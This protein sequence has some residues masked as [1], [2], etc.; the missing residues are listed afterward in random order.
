MSSPIRPVLILVRDGWG[1]AP[2][3]PGN[4]VSLAK[5]PRHDDLLKRFPVALVNASEHHVGLPVGQMGNSEVG[6]MSMG[7]GRVVHQ[8]F[9]R[10]EQDLEAHG[11]SETEAL[12]EAIDRAQERDRALHLIGLCSPGGVHSH[13]RHLRALLRLARERDVDEVYVHVITDG[14]DTSP[15]GGAD[16]VE[17]IVGWTQEF[18]AKIATVSGRYYAMDRDTRWDRIKQAYDAL[19][20]GRGV[21]I[22]DPVAYLRKCY[23]E[24][25]GDEFVLPAVVHEGGRRVASLQAGD[26][27][28]AFNF[29]ADRMRQMCQALMLHE[30]SDFDRGTSRVWELA[31]MTQYQDSLPFR[32]TAFPPQVIR[33][34]LCE[35]VSRTGRSQFKCAET[36]KYAHVTFFWNGGVE[37]PCPGEER[38]LIPS[39][40]VATYDL[41]PEMC[42]AAVADGV[43]GRLKS[44][45]DALLV[46]NL[47]NTDMVGHTGDIDATVVA[48][49]AVDAAVGQM[50]DAMLAKGG[51]V[52]ITADHGNCEQMLD[53]ETGAVHT[54]HTTN[55]VQLIACG[56]GLA[57]RTLRSGGGLSSVGPTALDLLGIERPAAMTVSSLLEN[58]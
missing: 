48:V 37:A 43:T 47:A 57:G 7:A 56:E 15:R 24:D 31:S 21:E 1:V 25:T 28:V 18:G 46:V 44:H 26:Q 4:A 11:F 17:E 53:L 40:R 33:D 50:V 6:H 14:R 39:P 9:A 55:P 20:H 38:L 36:E 51:C 19:A 30:F 13:T 32:G 54:A 16:Y 5:T 22:T 27:I 23:R 2:D 35:V 12:V 34:H 45:D 49:E 41:Q 42:A 29:R 3:A 52:L 8:D 58:P 10:I